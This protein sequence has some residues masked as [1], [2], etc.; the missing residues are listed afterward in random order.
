MVA[1]FGEFA[2]N[3]FEYPLVE[4]PSVRLKT[5]TSN[6]YS[7]NLSEKTFDDNSFGYLAGHFDQPEFYVLQAT[8]TK[9]DHAVGGLG[10]TFWVAQEGHQ[11]PLLF[12]EK[13]M[14]I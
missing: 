1:D 10:P 3:A 13:K 8:S 9:K 12:K 4:F 14:K 11:K 2:G 7:A 5:L 6:H